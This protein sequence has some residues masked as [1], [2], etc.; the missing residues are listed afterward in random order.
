YVEGRLDPEAR[1]L[2]EERLAADPALRL[3][4]EDL[5]ALRDQM[6]LSRP[7]ATP[8]RALLLAGLAAAAA[9]A[10]LAFWLGTPA[11]Q[12]PTAPPT[13]ASLAP[14]PRFALKDGERRVALASDGAVSGLPSLDS[15]L[16]AAV[17]GALR[18]V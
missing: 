3:E 7:I 13:L 17:A 15:G 5:V 4:V 11:V 9:L 6:R 8:R 14:A 18:G 10:A 16:H 2:L 1:A 12:A